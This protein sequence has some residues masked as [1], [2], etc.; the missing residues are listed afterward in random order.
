M[1]NKRCLIKA[2]D[3][4]NDTRSNRHVFAL[5]NQASDFGPSAGTF[6][7]EL[8]SSRCNFSEVDI[9]FYDEHE[10]PRD[11]NGEYIRFQLPVAYD[12]SK[13][14][15]E[16]FGSF[17]SLECARAFLYQRHQRPLLDMQKIQTLLPLY[18]RR[19]LGS[20]AVLDRRQYGCRPHKYALKRYGG[21]MSITDFRSEWCNSIRYAVYR[22]MPS[23][24]GFRQ[25]QVIVDEYMYPTTQQQQQQHATTTVSRE[26]NVGSA[27]SV[28]TTVSLQR[29]APV[30]TGPTLQFARRKMPVHM[31]KQ[32]LAALIVP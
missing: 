6:G 5:A 3:E 7:I 22:M 25:V 15:F 32:T 31:R 18:A 9:C 11:N 1:S 16:L 12:A 27:S 10:L 28:S 14:E 13:K 24:P 23:L 8:R 17:C 29:H 4:C 21:P 26:N 2:V 19:V 30:P 20:T